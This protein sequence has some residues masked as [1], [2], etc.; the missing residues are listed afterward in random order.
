VHDSVV[1][2]FSRK[3]ASLAFPMLHLVYTIP[4]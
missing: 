4:P 1:G 3:A 2:L